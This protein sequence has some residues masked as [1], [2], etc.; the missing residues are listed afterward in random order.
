M[1]EK[2]NAVLTCGC[3]DEFK[4]RVEQRA[5]SEGLSMADVVRLAVARELRR[6]KQEAAADAA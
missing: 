6:A 3:T 5:A 1:R 4:S 2:F